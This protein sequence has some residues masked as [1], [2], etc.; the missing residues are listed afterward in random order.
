MIKLYYTTTAGENELQSRFDKSLGGY[1][2]SSLVLNDDFDN[3]FGD[4]S[5]YTIQNSDKSNYIGIIIKN[6]GV[7]K[8]DINIWFEYP[9]DSYSVIELAAVDLT[10]DSDGF[11]YMENIP[12]I[13]STPVYADF[14]EADGEVNKLNI[15]GL[16]SD[17]AVGI[18]LKRTIDRDVVDVDRE[19][20]IITDP[21]D[22][23]RVIM[24]ELSKSDTIEVKIEYTE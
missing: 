11:K 20:Q 5:N 23:N 15:G 16:L 10:T 14:Y 4:I 13:S 7:D 6:E 1:K 24:Q 21:E 8:T 18:W 12:T 3:F 2:S 9:S 22:E 19:D 17:E